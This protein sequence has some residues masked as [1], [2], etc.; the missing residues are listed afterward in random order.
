MLRQF[1]FVSKI[2][3]YVKLLVNLQRMKK[4]TTLDVISQSEKVTLYS[5]SFERDGTTEFENIKNGHITIEEK[6][7]GGI[8]DLKLQI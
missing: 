5:I 3:F 6:E 7:L 8:E 1:R 2:S 4:P